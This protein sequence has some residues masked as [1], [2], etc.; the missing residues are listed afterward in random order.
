M[1][2]KGWFVFSALLF[3][4][5]LGLF[6]I[7]A[8]GIHDVPPAAPGV[9]D[10]WSER[11]AAEPLRAAPQKVA[12]AESP[13]EGW[14]F[15][16]RSVCISSNVP[17]APL[18]AVVKL[19]QG[20]GGL[21][22]T[23]AGTAACWRRGFTAAQTVSFQLY[24]ASDRKTYKG[25]CAYTAPANYGNLTSVYIRINPT[26]PQRTA[27]GGG[28]EWLDVFGHEIGHAFGLS[29]AQPYVSSIMRDGH[30]LDASD[31]AK[32]SQIYGKRAK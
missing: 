13:L 16:R 22:I 32:L 1:E 27:C 14:A 29:H 24:T 4:A 15:T 8:H 11:P 25:Y 12:K 20:V 2:N 26:G 10:G 5:I 31:R 23:N 18:A 6:I 17:G 30:S 28:A 7:P 19:Y 21:S 9:T 3:A